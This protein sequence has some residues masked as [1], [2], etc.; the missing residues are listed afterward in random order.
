MISLPALLVLGAGLCAAQTGQPGKAV[1]SEEPSLVRA[2]LAALD[3]PAAGERQ[4]YE[5]IEIL[6][7]LLDKGMGKLA[8]AG[9]HETLRGSMTSSPDGRWLAGSSMAASPDGR[10]LAGSGTD[11]STTRY[12]DPRTGK[13]LDS[14]VLL[15]PSVTQGVY[16]KGQGIVLTLTLP[17]HLHRVVGGPDKTA[18]KPLTEWERARKELRGEKVEAEKAKER[19]EVSLADAVLRVL[20]DNGKNLTQLPE[21]ESVTVAITLPQA[22]T[23]GRAGTFTPSGAPPG[24]VTGGPGAPPGGTGPGQESSPARADFRKYALLGDLALKQN[25]FAQAADGYRKAVSLHQNLPRD[26]ATDLEVIEVTTKLARAL[27]AQ[28]KK[29]EAEKFVQ[30]LGKLTSGLGSVQRAGKPAAGEIALPAK[31]IITVPKKLLDVAGSPKYGF[32]EFR[33]AA[34]VEYLTFDKAAEKPKGGDSGK[35]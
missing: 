19:D 33:K 24:G 14:H 31:L 13:Y 3:T 11:F 10:W 29:D 2:E 17:H 5:E 25:D 20:A 21:G 4:R 7:R 1:E 6:A 16:L 34:S 23:G 30:A 27:L 32:D 28:G 12:W 9:P 18:P 35:P 8:G 15:V 26:S 22:Q